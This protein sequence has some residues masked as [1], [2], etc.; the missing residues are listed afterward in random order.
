MTIPTSITT[1]L[2]SLQTQVAAAAPLNAAS[3]PT[4]TALQ[5]NAEALLKQVDA[6]QYS[7]AGALDTWT[8]SIDPADITTGVVGLLNSAVDERDIVQMRGII[9]RAVSNLNQL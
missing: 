2:T 4:I 5:L 3:R 1:A 6:A 9:G 8:P 7:L